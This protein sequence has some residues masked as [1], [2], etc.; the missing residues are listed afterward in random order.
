MY[1][2]NVLNKRKICFISNIHIYEFHMTFFSSYETSI[3]HHMTKHICFAIHASLSHSCG[4]KKCERLRGSKCI[5]NSKFIYNVQSHI[6]LLLCIRF[7]AILCW[8]H[9][10]WLI[11]HYEWQKQ[12]CARI[13]TKY[14]KNTYKFASQ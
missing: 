2:W 9:I 7:N 4:I 6:L 3:K 5:H 10:I 14:I 11:C 1:I 13:G 8:K 12:V